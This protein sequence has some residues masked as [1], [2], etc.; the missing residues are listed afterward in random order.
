MRHPPTASVAVVTDSSADL[1]AELVGDLE[2]AVVPLRV[3]IGGVQYLE[4]EEIGAEDVTEAM[5]TKVAVTTSRPSPQAFLATYARLVDAGF[6]AVVS[7]HLSAEVSGTYDS[8]VLAA[9]ESP[10]P[11]EVVDTRTLALG[12]GFAVRAAARTAATGGSVVEVAAAARDVAAASR[13]LFYVDTL[14]YLRRGGRLSAARALLGSALAVKP[15]LHVAEGRIELLE[16]VRT[17]SRARARLADLAVETAGD[18]PVDLAVQHLAA[19]SRAGELADQ[20]SA[21][22]PAAGEVIVREVGAAVGAHVGPG[23]VAVVIA[24]RR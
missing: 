15:I 11:V 10:A 5:R 9:A 8:A 22:I 16:K 23:M 7:V 17:S 6:D 21:R 13:S 12:L 1:S 4:G 19:A 18:R 3:V 14:E 24:P 2:I 20:L